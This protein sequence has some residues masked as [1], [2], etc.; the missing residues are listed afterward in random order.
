MYISLFKTALKLILRKGVY[1]SYAQFGEDLIIR[2]FTQAKT[3][4]YVDVGCYH[5][6]LYSNTYRLYRAGWHGIVIDP[7]TKSKRAFKLFRPR[8]KFVQAGVGIKDT[9]TYFEFDDGAY[10]TFSPEHAESYKKRAR[11][12]SSHEVN[13]RPLSEILE[14]VKSIDVLSI[15]VEGLDL[16][17]L[18]THDW[19]VFPRIILIEA[20]PGSET[21]NFLVEKGYVLVGLTKLNSIFL[22]E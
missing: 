3:G 7:N 16:E 10:N 19:Q 5:P 1:S 18:K 17:V 11:L 14:G 21:C 15:D 9:K 13:L 8:D 2:P 4:F 12:I 6:I 22:Y 20:K